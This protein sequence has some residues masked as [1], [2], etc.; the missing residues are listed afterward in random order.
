MKRIGRITLW[1][2]GSIAGLIL[3]AI[4]LI[5][6]F[7]PIEKA[8]AFAVEK[9]SAALGRPVM[10]GD[11]DVSIWGGIGVLL[12]NVAIGNP[13]GFGEG[14]LASIEQVDVKLAFWPLLTGDYRV[15]RLEIDR[16]SIA[17]RVLPN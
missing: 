12:K 2:G 7:F 1:I 15:N 17:L 9:G 11:V 3:L 8:K 16:P 14:N 13:P 4:I 5:K 10:V 6:I